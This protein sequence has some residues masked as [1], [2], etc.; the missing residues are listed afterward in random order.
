[1]FSHFV[2]IDEYGLPDLLPENACGLIEP[3][4]EETS[5][6]SSHHSPPEMQFCKMIYNYI[7]TLVSHALQ[8]KLH[9]WMPNTYNTMQNRNWFN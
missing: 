3:A 6:L 2:E 5:L 8:L 9:L 1:M 7:Q 4:V